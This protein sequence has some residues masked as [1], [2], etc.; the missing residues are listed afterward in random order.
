MSYEEAKRE[1]MK[2]YGVGIKVAECVC[3]FALQHVDA[4]P[5]DTHIRQ[6]LQAHYPQGFP[7]LRYQ[8][9][10]GILQQLMFYYE[11]HGDKSG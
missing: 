9:I 3:L 2:L 5:V 4:F 11:L 7:F 10:A 1:L 6:I 8:G